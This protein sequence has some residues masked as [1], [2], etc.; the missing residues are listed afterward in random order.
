ME[1]IFINLIEW[2]EL[3]LKTRIFENEYGD[4]AIVV[5]DTYIIYDK[6]DRLGQSCD[7]FTEE[8][9][10]TYIRNGFVEIPFAK[11]EKIKYDQ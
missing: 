10:G 4:R 5:S 1:H 6:V 2:E 8:I 11:L 3:R 7:Y 9:L